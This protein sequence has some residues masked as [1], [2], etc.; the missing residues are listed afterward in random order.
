MQVLETHQQDTAAVYAYCQLAT[1]LLGTDDKLAKEY[2]YRAQSISQRLNKPGLE[3][4][5]KNLIGLAYDYLGVPDSALLFYQGS[6]EIKR[7]LND[8]DGMAASNMNIGV[9]YYY[10]NDY[11]KAVTYYDIAMKQFKQVNNEKRIAG[12]LNNLGTIYREQK[13]YKEAIDVFNQSYTLKV[14]INDSTGMSNALG[15]LGIVYQHMKQYD[16]AE[17][18]MIQSLNIDIRSNNKYNQLSSCVSL[19]DLKLLQNKYEEAK[20]H[21]DKA[22]ELG[23]GLDAD[24]YMDDAYKVYTRLDSMTGDYQSAFRH[25]QLQYEFKNKVIRDER[26]KQLDRLETVY[27]TKEKEKE[28]DLLNANAQIK[29]LQLQK[30]KKQ[31]FTFIAISASLLVGLILFVIGFRSIRRAKRELQQKNEIINNSLAEKEMLLKEIHHRVKNNLQVISSLLS[32]QSRYIKDEK[33]LETINESME[34]VNAISILHQEI[35]QNEV[36]RA[37]NAKN[38]FENLSKGLQQT[39]DPDKKVD[40]HLGLDDIMTDVDQLIPLGLIVNELLTNAYKYGITNTAPS[41]W[42]TVLQLDNRIRINVRDNGIGF[43]ETI[44]GT[45]GTSLG[46]KLINMFTTKLKGKLIVKNNNGADTTIE[47]EIKK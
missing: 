1:E 24:H 41:I 47:C 8:I 35:Y 38:Y 26:Q 36:L 46:Y 30:Q 32:V 9:L 5:A 16:K 25:I 37:I 19:A 17:Q 20:Q 23:K 15:N 21:L 28:I 22:I 4:W 34:R 43:G 31:L 7:R 45:G 42:L 14:K 13:K 44:P 27:S 12:I 18:L 10:Q 33:A 2:A 40:L 39:F 3:A 29:N 11:T 6:I